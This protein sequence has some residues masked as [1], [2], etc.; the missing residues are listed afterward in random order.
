MSLDDLM[1]ELDRRLATA[2]AALAA[3]YP[4]DRG[5]RQPVHPVYVPADRYDAGT[6]DDWGAQARG[7][8]DE[9]GGSAAELADVLDLPAGLAGGGRAPGGALPAGRGGGG[10]GGGGP[11]LAG[12]P[13]EDLRI[14]FEDGYGNRPDDEEDAAAVAAA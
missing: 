9:Y 7:A 10:A 13:I 8:L 12:E 4:G 2:D 6:V 11:R 1:A 14:D 5:A 3:D